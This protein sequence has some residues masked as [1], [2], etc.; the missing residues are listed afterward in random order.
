MP[1]FTPSSETLSTTSRVFPIFVVP[2]P[3]PSGAPPDLSGLVPPDD[4]ITPEQFWAQ[5]PK[6]WRKT[7]DR[8]LG[9]GVSRDI[10]E[11]IANDAWWKASRR[12]AEL[13]RRAQ[14]LAWV[15]TIALSMMRDYFRNRDSQNV[16]LD[17]PHEK[18]VIVEIDETG[19]EVRDV[20]EQLDPRYRRA[21]QLAYCEGLPCSEVAGI[22][23]LETKAVYEL[24]RRGRAAFVK[25]MNG[26]G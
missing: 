18:A 22:L 20:L 26:R 21:L 10:A 16:Q 5:Y 17:T 11:D 7:V 24:L 14:L 9:W 1:N 6:G 4:P 3:P 25:A 23:N 8:L 19:I 2:P 12:L 15:N 13:Q